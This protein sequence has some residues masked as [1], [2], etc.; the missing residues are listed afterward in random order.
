LSEDFAMPL[1]VFEGRVFPAALEVTFSDPIVLG[2]RDHPTLPNC[3]LQ[4]ILK[5]GALTVECDIERFDKQQHLSLLWKEVVELS[6]VSVTMLTF[7]TGN[8]TTI[9]F[10]AMTLPG[11]SRTQFRL[12][13]D[14]LAQYCTAFKLAGPTFQKVHDLALREPLIH[15]ALRDLNESITSPN[16]LT[17]NCARVTETIRTLI[18]PL[19][20]K[21]DRR[22]AWAKMQQDLNLSEGYIKY[23]SEP[24]LSHRHG[25]FEFVE[26]DTN[27]EI[28]RRVWIIVN[29]F[30]EYRLRGNAPLT[31]P[32]FP[33]L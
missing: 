1:V 19:G 16:R 10:D 18:H 32:E 29:R 20:P 14:S 6:G 30:W 12:S 31:A 11:E 2:W 21:D 13:N 24:A 17:A 25:T 22:P 26:G 9:V 23:A 4:V 7:A 3:E 27:Q 8:G 5:R 28:I 33:L 15:Y